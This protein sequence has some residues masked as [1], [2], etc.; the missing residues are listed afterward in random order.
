M[1][2]RRT[3][4][5]VNEYLSEW[6]VTQELAL[7]RSTYE[8]VEIYITRHLMPHFA[9]KDLADL[10]A[11]DIQ[12]YAKT[13]LTN[14]R[15]DRKPG[16][17]S[18]VSVR[19][20]ISVFKQALNDAVLRGYIP[21]N[22]ASVIRLPRNRH[23]LSARAVLLTAEDAQRVIA[24]FAGHNLQPAV[25]LTLYYGLRRSEVLGLKW[26]AVDFQKDTITIR[27]TVVK[28]RTIVA[29]DTTKTESSH[30][31]YQ[32][33]PEVKEQLLRLYQDRPCGSEYI[34]VW[35]DGRLMRPDYVTRGFQRVL[36]SHGLPVMRFHDLRHSTASIL[37]DRGWSL[38]DVKNW[39]GHAD[40]ETTSNIYLHYNQN[41]K[42]LLAG[43]L[44]GIFIPTAKNSP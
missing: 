2:K 21:I 18:L 23:K 38:E 37:F 16:G 27:H 19:K 43:S 32:M 10:K 26:S 41:R 40:L 5:T 6:L 31:T 15:L 33:I 13:K 4:T 25:V 24:A 39:L 22:P 11:I 3:T 1:Q 28:N 14:G 34:N 9:G 17:L 44:A 20:H 12:N 7:R 30:R 36:R 29:N 8:S 42:V 35:P